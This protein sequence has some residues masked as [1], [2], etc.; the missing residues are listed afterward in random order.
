MGTG[1][2]PIMGDLSFAAM[3]NSSKRITGLSLAAMVGRQHVFTLNRFDQ[4]HAASTQSRADLCGKAEFVVWGPVR[5][6]RERVGNVG[7]E[8]REKS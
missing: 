1:C 7:R 3:V 5:V 6:Q 8:D 4:G 2:A